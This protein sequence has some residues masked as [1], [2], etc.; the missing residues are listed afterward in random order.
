MPNI[1]EQ[2]AKVAHEANRAWCAVNGDDSQTSWEDAPD[3]QRESAIAGVKFHSENPDANDSASHDNWAA[4]KIN[5]GWGYGE[6]KDPEAKTHPCLVPFYLLPVV[7]QKKD[8][9]F[10]AICH[11]LL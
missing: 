1:F 4:Q 6:V 8:A 7:Q 3:W 2:I 5:D 10:R 11:A 9:M